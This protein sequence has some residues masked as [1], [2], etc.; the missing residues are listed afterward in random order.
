MNCEITPFPT[1]PEKPANSLQSCTAEDGAD[2][3]L[4]ER[5]PIN[6]QLQLCWEERKSVQRQVRVRVVDLSTCGF[7]VGS[8]R[9]IPAGTVVNVYTARFTPIGRASVRHCAPKGLDYRIDL[10]MPDRFVP[11]R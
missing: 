6:T 7:Q 3:R 10:Y 2:R 9:A 11:D 4:Y 1:K 8:E 5:L